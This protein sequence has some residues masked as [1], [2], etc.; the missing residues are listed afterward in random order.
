MVLSPDD[1]LKLPDEIRKTIRLD[2]RAKRKRGI[3]RRRPI[4]CPEFTRAELIDYVRRNNFRKV[5][6]VFAASGNGNPTLWCFQKNF[7]TNFWSLVKQE[8]F[9]PDSI[10]FKWHDD[11]DAG[12][13]M[14]L[15]LEF[16]LWTRDKY[17]KARLAHSD[18]VPPLNRIREKWGTFRRMKICARRYSIKI[19]LDEYLK[20]SRRLGRIPS[21]EDCKQNEVYID[22]VIEFFEGKKYLDMFLQMMEKKNAAK[23]RST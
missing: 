22:K 1:I 20:L 5:S 17:E 18:I 23:E 12:Y 9:S 11:I 15:V 8:A 13:L 7:G 4:R 6:Q 14:K 10:R 16:G 19:M 3:R 21:V 2:L